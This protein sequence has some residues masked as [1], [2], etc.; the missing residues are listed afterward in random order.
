[1]AVLVGDRDPSL[2]LCQRALVGWGTVVSM[3]G[4][5]RDVI[6]QAVSP[7]YAA[8][9]QGASAE[10]LDE[11]Y[12]LE[13]VPPLAPVKVEPEDQKPV[14]KEPCDAEEVAVAPPVLPSD[15]PRWR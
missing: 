7:S 10:T 3:P 13:P 9:F 11:S 2:V 4:P 14:K 6:A 15:S 8:R 5:T 1:M 12:G